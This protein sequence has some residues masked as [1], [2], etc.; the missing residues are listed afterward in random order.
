MNNLV[1]SL[2]ALLVFYIVLVGEFLLPTGGLL[3]AM[4]AA[5]L[6]TSVVLAFKSST[7]AGICVSCFIAIT[8]PFFIM[9]LIR[10]WPNTP[11]GKRMLNLKRGQ[12]TQPPCKTTSGGTPLDQLI[13]QTGTAKTNLLPSGLVLINGEK[14]DAVSTGMPIDAGTQ[15]LV[16]KTETGHVQVRELITEEIEKKEST[17]PTSPKLLEDSL[18]SFDFE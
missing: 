15:I 13:G 10:I 16:V 7:A 11:V 9:F 12:T 2:V 17:E 5:A 4:A 1:Y 6:I 18:D 14:I 3:G 8:S